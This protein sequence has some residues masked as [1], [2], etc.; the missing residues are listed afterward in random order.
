MPN[1]FSKVQVKKRLIPGVTESWISAFLERPA[2]RLEAPRPKRQ[3]PGEVEARFLLAFIKSL[4][5]HK[6][7]TFLKV[8]VPSRDRDPSMSA[9]QKEIAGGKWALTVGKDGVVLLPTE[10]EGVAALAVFLLRQ[11]N[12][13]SRVR[14]CRQCSAWFY[15]RFKHKKFCSV[16]CQVDAYHTPRWRKRNREKN[17]RRQRE[18]R[19]RLFGRRD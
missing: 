3:Y 10:P 16:K 11:R 13:L 12:L 4:S 7:S 1:A 9:L 15:A 19:K 17:L 14:Q 18:Y 6:R 5:P 8:L 2:F